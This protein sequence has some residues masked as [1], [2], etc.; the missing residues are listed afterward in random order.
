MLSKQLSDYTKI[1]FVP[2]L[3]KFQIQSKS[4]SPNNSVKLLE[5]T[6]ALFLRRACDIAA[7]VPALKV[8]FNN[9]LLPI[10]SF[11]DYIQLFKVP[12]L[13]R[14]ESTPS[15]Q[16]LPSKSSDSLNNTDSGE[17]G[18][19]D[20]ISTDISTSLQYYPILYHK[21]ND[22][23]EVGVTRSTSSTFENISFVNCVWTPEGGS[24][25]YV[26]LNQIL[27]ALD[28]QL[29]KKGMTTKLH[30][31]FIKNKLKLFVKATIENP[32]FESQSKLS[33]SSKPNTFG[34]TYDL[35]TTFLKSI[36]DKL[37]IVNEILFDA[38]LREEN[39]LLKGFMSKKYTNSQSH[40]VNVPKLEDAV[41][42][43]HSKHALECTL[44]LTEGDSAKALAIAGLEAVGRERYGVLP[45][46]GEVNEI[47]A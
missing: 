34:S 37:G 27:R 24:H 23:W 46:R 21:I 10:K 26:V 16:S 4:K 28:E 14:E 31:N 44:I 38:K 15:N 7:C 9:N 6:V 25:V 13:D 5:D 35:S 17:N 42:A 41:L 29:I 22:R 33:L 19:V 2:D 30:P 18:G 12:I 32:S 11:K 47:M 8:S 45:L 3:T 40:V 39:K 20:D 36:A 43:G 1:S